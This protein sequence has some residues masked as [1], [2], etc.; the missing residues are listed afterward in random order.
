[1]ELRIKHVN[2]IGY[3]SEVKTGLFPAWKKIGKHV[4]GF[5]L[6]ESSCLDHPMN[7]Q[8]EALS[9]CKLYK[10]LANKDATASFTKVE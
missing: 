4:N 9:R 2:G 10:E 5:G 6:Y 3:F 7:T 8:E 1:M